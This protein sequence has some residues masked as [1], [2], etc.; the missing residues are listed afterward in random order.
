MQFHL[1]ACR[2]ECLRSLGAPGEQR[3]GVQVEGVARLTSN[4]LTALC[5]ALKAS[6]AHRRSLLKRVKRLA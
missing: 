6:R 1:G 4:A 5:D 2:F 3:W